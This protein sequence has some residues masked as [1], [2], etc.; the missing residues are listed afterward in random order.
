[1]PTESSTE[2]RA[3]SSASTL[4]FCAI[5]SCSDS[6]FSL[7]FVVVFEVDPEATVGA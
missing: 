4:S 1:M 6:S 7:P 2:P 5:N 3:D